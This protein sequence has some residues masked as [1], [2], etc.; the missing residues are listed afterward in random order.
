M[1]MIWIIP[2]RVLF[3]L[4]IAAWSYRV[5]SLEIWQCKGQL[6]DFSSPQNDAHSLEWGYLQSSKELSKGDKNL[7]LWFNAY[8]KWNT[9][10]FFTKGQHIKKISFA[11]WLKFRMI[12][13]HLPSRF[14]QN[15]A[16][17]SPFWHFSTI[18]IL[19]WN[20][21]SGNT[22]WVVASVFL[23]LAKWIIFGIFDVLLST[24][25][26]RSSLR[27]QWDFFCNF[28]TPW[29]NDLISPILSVC[30]PSKVL[31]HS[32]VKVLGFTYA[33]Y[34]KKIFPY[35]RSLIVGFLREFIW[36]LIRDLISRLENCILR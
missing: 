10:A 25:N 31:L 13:L 11:L 21:M 18:L 36:Y 14:T 24:Q 5:P 23:K 2:F 16:A 19:K 6:S 26:I 17:K 34:T 33:Y 22:V 29:P 15:A 35:R 7:A 20:W 30:K 32:F 9:K 8:D 28:Q 1:M 12:I 27:S 4:L 3:I